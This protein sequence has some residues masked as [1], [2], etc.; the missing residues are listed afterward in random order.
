MPDALVTLTFVPLMIFGFGVIVAVHEFGHFVAARW[1]G[2]RVHAFAVGFGRAIVSYRKGFGVSAGSSEARYE[3]MLRAQREGAEGADL[4]GVSPTEYRLNWIPFGGY[5]KMLGQDDADPSH[6]SDEPDSYQSASIF[7]RMVVISAGVV[8]NVVLAALL[9]IAVYMVGIAEPSNVI[10]RPSPGSVADRA[11]FEAG[12][13]VVRVGDEATPSFRDVMVAVALSPVGEDLSFEVVRT[14]ADGGEET[15][16]LSAAPLPASASAMRVPSVELPGSALSCEVW[17]DPLRSSDEQT[18]RLVFEQAGLAGL[19]PGSVLVSVGG[20][21]VPVREHPRTGERFRMLVDAERLIGRAVGGGTGEPGVA[22]GAGEEV[23]LVFETP[24]GASAA[25]TL[26]AVLPLPRQ[27]VV[28]EDGRSHSS[29]HLL[30]LTPVLMVSDDPSSPAPAQ[31]L[32]RGDVLLRVGSVTYPSV[33]AGIREIRANRGGSIDLLVLRGDEVIPLE[34]NVSFE[35]TVGFIPDE[36]THLPVLARTPDYVERSGT[37][38][39]GEP[40]YEDVSLAAERLGLDAVLPGTL[41]TRFAGH[42]VSSFAE[43]LTAAR[44]AVGSAAGDSD[45]ADAS[46]DRNG[47]V[48]IDVEA[49]S[50]PGP[51]VGASPLAGIEARSGADA[52]FALTVTR[53][54]A[55]ELMAIE[56]TVR[57]LARVFRPASTER[58]ADG[59]IDAVVMGAHA[60]KRIIQQTYLTLRRLIEGTVPVNQLQGPVGIT[61]TGSRLAEQG[62]IY[63]LYF[64]ALIS[65]NLAVINFLPIP[66]TDGGQFL[67]LMYEAVFRRPVPIVA[68]NILT[69]MGLLA[70][71]LVFIYVTFHDILRIF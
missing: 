28:V 68:Q 66:I 3:Q 63:M 33:A 71:G 52:G 57:H 20:E 2:I 38:E 56:P 5:V 25:Y 6:R 9:F 17:P 59:P 69:L 23:E 30:G 60:T 39:A 15:V 4:S 8:L 49:V 40:E 32:Q 18:L 35:G 46:G 47:E 19:Q 27:T 14:G 37:D 42:E 55:R 12:D 53:S 41:V 22:G 70:I 34:A 61:Y 43:M 7:K 50:L 13:V 48:T 67:L 26:P 36:A 65:A 45:G 54:E 10:D 64:L 1:A 29:R 24:G 31:G 58:I 51:V 44:R 16:T 21:A 62:P 11:G